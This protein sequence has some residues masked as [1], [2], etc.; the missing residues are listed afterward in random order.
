MDW[1]FENTFVQGIISHGIL[2]YPIFQANLHG[3]YC[4][5]QKHSNGER[6]CKDVWNYHVYIFLT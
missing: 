2:V 1:L 4:S 6:S 3:I 5:Q